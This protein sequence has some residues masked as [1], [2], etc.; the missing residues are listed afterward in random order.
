MLTR[1]EL[2]RGICAG[3][4]PGLALRWSA[5]G[6]GTRPPARGVRRRPV[7][8]ALR[9]PTGRRSARP[10]S[11]PTGPASLRV[12]PGEPLLA[13]TELGPASPR[14]AGRWQPWPTSPTPTCSTPQ[15]P[16]RV[17]LPRRVSDP[18]FQLDLPTPRDAHRSG[19]RRHADGRRPRS[20][21]G[22]RAPGRRPDRQRAGQRAR[23]GARGARRRAGRRRAAEARGTTASSDASN[24]DPLYYRPDL[25]APRHPGMLADAL[26]PF[27]SRASA[28]AVAPRARRPRPARRR[29]SSRR[30]RRPRAIA[31]G[32]ARRLEAAERTAPPRSARSP[33][34]RDRHP[35]GSAT[36]R[37]SAE[38]VSRLLGSAGVDV[39][40][41]PRR[42]ELSARRGRSLGCG[43]RAHARG[44]GASAARSGRCAARRRRGPPRLRLRR[45]LVGPGRSSS[46]WSGANGGSGGIVAPDQP[47]WLAAELAA[48]GDRTILVFSHQPLRHDGRGP[49]AARRARPVTAACW[50][51][52]GGTPT[53]TGSP[54]GL[55]R[56]AATG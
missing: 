28:R 54:P 38:L 3:A 5:T 26:R 4:G 36:R 33:R 30:R 43:A 45:R 40:A 13:R 1:R 31:T 24:P 50:R 34:S 22:C 15:S 35:T 6:L 14:P 51:R 17:H 48:A 18:P 25:D 41:D 7:R 55:G 44:P 2:V 53:A 21:P 10:G 37:R 49:R 56:A 29:A 19:P 52:S 11:T 47:A 12:G 46:T 39:P 32:V 20:P 27:A 16:A 23:L 42:A 8:L 9:R